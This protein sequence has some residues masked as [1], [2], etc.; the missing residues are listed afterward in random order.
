MS[1]YTTE[2]LKEIWAK[3]EPS[4]ANGN[5]AKWRKDEYGSLMKYDDYGD[6]TSEYGWEVDHIISLADGGP[7]E[8]S[9]WQPLQWENKVRKSGG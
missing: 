1:N 5:A 2:Q 6:R 4:T 8:M 7:D 3:G 9:N